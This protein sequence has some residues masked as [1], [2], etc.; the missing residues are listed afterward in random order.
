MR[1]IRT[2]Y[3]YLETQT[4]VRTYIPNAWKF[5]LYTTNMRA[6]IKV[7]RI[8]SEIVNFSL[9]KEKRTTF[10]RLAVWKKMHEDDCGWRRCCCCRCCCCYFIYGGFG[11]LAQLSNRGKVSCSFHAV[12]SEMIHLSLKCFKLVTVTG[13]SPHISWAC[14][15]RSEHDLLTLSDI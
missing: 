3:M 2:Y 5:G 15:G 4:D 14:G 11:P 13:P 10:V 9:A 12:G 1:Y 7:S 6:L 8:L